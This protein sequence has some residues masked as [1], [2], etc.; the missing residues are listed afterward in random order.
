M[1]QNYLTWSKTVQ[2]FHMHFWSW[3]FR[4]ILFLGHPV[5]YRENL[6]IERNHHRRITITA[7]IVLMTIISIHMVILWPTRDARPNAW[8]TTPCTTSTLVTRSRPGHFLFWLI[9][10]LVQ[11]GHLD[12]DLGVADSEGD[13]PPRPRAGLRFA[14][15]L[16]WNNPGHAYSFQDDSIS[17]QNYGNQNLLSP[18]MTCTKKLVLTNCKLTS[19]FFLS[20]FFGWL[21]DKPRSAI[22]YSLDKQTHHKTQGT[23]YKEIRIGNW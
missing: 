20:P 4:K 13:W 16:S 10:L 12:L 15:D 23:R 22:L 7:I 21:G 5:D 1:V 3:N 14:W 19:V 17:S 2:I 8:S 11:I 18:T 9:L 6:D